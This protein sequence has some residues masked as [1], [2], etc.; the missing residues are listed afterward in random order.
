MSTNTILIDCNQQQAVAAA[1]A[2]NPAIWTNKISEGLQLNPGDRV[3][4]SSAFINEVGSGQNTIQFSEANNS[5]TLTLEF[6]KCADAENCL[7]LP[8]KW[9]WETVSGSAA[10][11]NTDEVASRPAKYAE[12]PDVTPHK[13]LY[14]RGHDGARYTIMK[15]YFID[16]DPVYA[17]GGRPLF[18]RHTTTVALSVKPGYNTADNICEQLTQQLHA[19]SAPAAYEGVSISASSPLF[20]P[21]VCANE[22]N[23]SKANY[24]STSKW[25]PYEFVG[26]HDLEMYLQGVT[27]GA[28]LVKHSTADTVTTDW[29][30]VPAKLNEMKLLFAEQARRGDLIFGTVI[31]ESNTRFLHVNKTDTHGLGS[32]DDLADGSGRLFVA[33]DPSLSE[34]YADGYGFATNDGG[35]IQFTLTGDKVH[36]GITVTAG[37]EPLGTRAIG[38]DTHFSAYGVDAILL[39][40][41]YDKSQFGE[42]D[43][44]DRVYLGA[45]D[46]DISFDTAQSRF[47]ISQLHTA[48]QQINTAEAG[49]PSSA[50]D[51]YPLNPDQGK[52]IYQINPEYNTAPTS[53]NMAYNPEVRLTAHH[54]TAPSNN[55]MKL[56]TVFDSMTGVFVTDWGVTEAGWSDGMWSKIGYSYADL[57]PATSTLDRQA[58]DGTSYPLTTGADVNATQLMQW[59]VNGYGAP[60]STLQLPLFPAAALFGPITVFATSTQ[61]VASTL[62]RQ[63]A[64]GYWLVRSSLVENPMYL[65]SRG[66]SPVIAVIDKS[67]SSQDYIY[68]GESTVDFLIT[69]QRTITDIVTS[70]HL[71]DGSYASVSDRS[72]VIYRIIKANNV[73]LSIIDSFLPKKTGGK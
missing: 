52:D 15:R 18:G 55:L 44:L 22:A 46:A 10:E 31:T 25:N 62:A 61:L 65:D 70:L 33:F 71:P 19:T 11:D 17:A 57:N 7:I 50:T 68:M 43:K 20:K 66:L 54:G 35:Y 9:C 47:V 67:Y 6:Y 1:D 4:V 27:V 39:W 37:A 30:Y 40:S 23:Y 32:D 5:A 36:G 28:T 38:F 72:A 14:R 51:S 45:N 56:W 8:R 41:G 48:R 21:F 58:R 2:G 24:T 63:Q 69:A 59:A 12:P 60:Q 42:A 64:A 13:E 34:S 49:K 26:M 3:S 29:V 53:R 73:P 16:G